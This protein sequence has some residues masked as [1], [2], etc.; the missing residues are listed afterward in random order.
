MKAAKPAKAEIRSGQEWSDQQGKDH[1]GFDILETRVHTERVE[2]KENR[3]V[4]TRMTWTTEVGNEFQCAGFSLDYDL[5][6][7]TF[8]ARAHCFQ[9]DYQA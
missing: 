1:G 9:H 3:G 2:H 8:N 4:E 5:L 7:R 6:F